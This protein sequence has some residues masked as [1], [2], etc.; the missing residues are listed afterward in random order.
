MNKCTT[1]M[2]LN[3]PIWSLGGIVNDSMEGGPQKLALDSRGYLLSL[4]CS[5]KIPART[6]G[7]CISISMVAS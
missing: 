3:F 5:T 1:E 2:L 7:M 6:F 4:Q